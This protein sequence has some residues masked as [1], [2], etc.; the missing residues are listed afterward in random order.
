M[1]FCRRA[2]GRPA[3]PRKAAK[4]RSF[5][6]VNLSLNITGA[7]D[8][9]HLLDTVV[10]GIDV[11]DTVC[12][13][14]RRDG[15]V[16][17]YMHGRGSEGIPPAQNN[18]VK[19]GEAFV[20]AF[21]TRGADIEIYKEIPIGAGL[22]GSSADA[23]G[24]LN[25]MA[26]LYAV[27]REELI[28]LAEKLDSDTPFLLVGGYARLGGRGERVQPLAA[29]RPLS[30]LL[31]WPASP[32]S[33]AACYREYDNEPDPPREDSARLCAA[34][35]QGDFAGVAANVYNALQR[36]ACTLNPEVT[37]ALAAVRALSPAACAVTGSGSAVFALFESE[38]LCAWAKSRL[39]GP[40]SS[41]VVRTP[42]PPRTLYTPFALRPGESAP[43]K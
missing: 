19:A 13:K 6:K 1:F 7:A 26:A 33:T 29:P 24:V 25:A 36:P 31:V 43:E 35:R 15:L 41:R 42:A 14:A 18:A 10:A 22:G 8:G 38:E 16:N 32:V 12:A 9:Y 11:Y 4:V 3:K 2:G 30:M 17:V 20:S 21:G 23:A 28:P 37:A 27:P 34:L 5:A 39:R 40:F